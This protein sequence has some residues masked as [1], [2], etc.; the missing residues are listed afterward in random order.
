MQG[1]QNS[2]SP[3]DYLTTEGD[4]LIDDCLKSIF[5][6][7]SRRL[8]RFLC[9]LSMGLFA[10][11]GSFISSCSR[12][13]ELTTQVIFVPN[14]IDDILYLG[15]FATSVR[16]VQLETSKDAL[17]GVV[18]HLRLHNNR[19]LV[20][21]RDKV[22]IFDLNGKFIQKLGSNGDGPGEYRNVYSLTVDTESGLVF[23]GSEREILSFSADYSFI[24]EKRFPMLIPY[25]EVV[26]GKLMVISEDIGEPVVSGFANRTA[27]YTLS[28]QLVL[29][30]SLLIKTVINKS[31]VTASFPFKHFLS[32]YENETYLY[33]PVLTTEDIIRDTL[34]QIKSGIL[35]PFL[36]FDFEASQ[37]VNEKGFK[38][39]NIMNVISSRSYY[40]ME[41]D[42]DF[43]RMAFLY[44]KVKL[45]GYN[46]KDGL[47]DERGS[48]V[49]LRPLDL[50][51]N[52]FYYVQAQEYSG[53]GVEELNPLVGIVKLK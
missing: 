1:G 39:I 29:S 12:S 37:S 21:D 32:S 24:E 31:V 41:Y 10:I 18:T 20:A 48:P 44:D 28:P 46:L 33:Y 25:I 49:S 14:S 22:L 23:I 50:E 3:N 17:L 4:F 19:I 9:F 51:N 6:Y 47:L 52:E 13:A 38:G 7:M 27:L 26:D 42:K 45:N 16:E 34:Y 11:L 53:V 5:C 2:L 15:D 30:D 8:N 36:K 43:K 35:M 40:V